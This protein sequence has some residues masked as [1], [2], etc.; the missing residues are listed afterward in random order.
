MS[1]A[2]QWIFIDNFKRK[3]FLKYELKRVLLKSIFRNSELPLIYRYFVFY[4]R[5]KAPRWAT[6]PQVVNRCS[7]TGRANSV[8][9]Q[10]KYSRF[11]HRTEAY[12]GNLPGLKR[13]SW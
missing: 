7:R 5:I 2:E 6:L 1:R 10:T 12:N 11:V 8:T 9:R 13:A 4:Q 3:L